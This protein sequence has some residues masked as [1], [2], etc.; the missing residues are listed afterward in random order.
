MT[1][2]SESQAP[3]RQAHD[4]EIVSEGTSPSTIEA[5]ERASI[6]V[7]IRTAH[8]FPRSMAEFKR[9]AL[10]MVSIDQETAASC[11]YRRP[12]G[13]VKNKA[14]GAWEEKIA[15]G[16][17]IRM[18]EIVGACY[19]NLRVMS[20]IVE[21]TPMYV[22]CR[23][24]AHDLESNFLNASEVIESTVDSN[25]NP[26]SP[27][28]RIVS[29]K[30]ALKKASRDAT[31]SVV[32]RALCKPLMREALK[33]EA[34]GRTLEQRRAAAGDWIK[35]LNI[36]EKRVFSA[37]GIKGL[38]D[39]GEDELSTLLGLRTAINDKDAT[40]DETFPKEGE[41]EEPEA[42]GRPKRE[43]RPS[44]AAAAAEAA[45]KGTVTP[46]ASTEAPPAPAAAPA[47]TQAP[48]ATIAAVAPAAAAAVTG[49]KDGQEVLFKGCRVINTELDLIALDPNDKVGQPSVIANIDGPYKGEVYHVG[50]ASIVDISDP[51]NPK[52]DAAPS[53]K[54]D[55]PVNIL[56]K[57]MKATNG[58]VLA[59]VQEIIVDQAA[60]TARKIRTL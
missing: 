18:A 42:P 56:L 28:Q 30:A 46:P 5:F 48:K 44:G 53:W 2:T 27:R 49:L 41:E 19:G 16:M 39:M 23:A 32:P 55:G 33:I 7:Q 11:I 31:F 45:A 58:T 1:P 34:G 21:Q 25:G 37:I 4:L 6:D 36:D 3:G 9:K 43:R 50:G 60:T 26:Y 40:I 8:E 12:V 51:K 14:T 13:K 29:A 10:D 57:G 15:E 20:M 22:K 59:M 35:S 52:L 54:F 24:V 17:S 38:A 47:E